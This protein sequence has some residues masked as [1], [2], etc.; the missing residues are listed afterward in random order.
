MDITIGI[1]L[2]VLFSGCVWTKENKHEYCL[3][4]STWGFTVPSGDIILEYGQS[5]N[6]TCNLYEEIAKDYINASSGLYFIYKEKRIPSDEVEIINSTSVRLYID[7]PPTSGYETYY[8]NFHETKPTKNETEK[9]VCMN[10][11]A[12]AVAPQNVTDFSCIG[13]NLDNL[14]CSWELPENYIKTDYILS[15][16]LNQ[17][18]SR[19]LQYYC[20]KLT[21][22][23]NRMS[24]FWNI[25]TKPQYRQVQPT[26]A[27]TLNMTNTFGSNLMKIVYD[28]FKHVIPNPPENLTVVSTSPHSIHLTW[29]IPKM[30]VYF[31]PGVH[32][33]IL[34]QCEYYE[35]KWEFVYITDWEKNETLEYDLNNMKYAHAVCDVRISMRSAVAVDDETMWSYYA[36]KTV[37]TKSDIPDLPPPM[38]QGCFEIINNQ[39]HRDVYIYW[40]QIGEEQKNGQNFK[41]EVV[42]ESHPNMKPQEQTKAYAKFTNLSATQYV[43]SVWSTNEKGKSENKSTVIIPESRLMEPQNFLKWDHP[44]TSLD[45]NDLY[46]LS[47]DAPRSSGKEITNYT[48]FWCNND[49]DRPHQ[50]TGNLNW[51]VIPV[52]ISKFNLSLP[53]NIIY[54]FAISANSENS[55]SGMSWAECTLIPSKIMGKMRNVWISLVGSTFIELGWKLE[56]TD[57]IRNVEGYRIY[58]CP[59][60]STLEK[61]CTISKEENVTIYGNKSLQSG[62]V[63]NLKPYTMYRLTVSVKVAPET[64]SQSSDIMINTT[65]E[66]APST[67]PK[68]INISN[69]TNSSLTIEWDPPTECNGVLKYYLINYRNETGTVSPDVNKNSK[70]FNLT[71]LRSYAKYFI[72]MQACTVQCSQPSE[73]QLVVTQ[74]WLPGDI[75]RPIVIFQNETVTTIQWEKPDDPR[76]EINYYQLRF[77][78]N[79][80]DVD[81][82]PVVNVTNAQN[83]SIK[84]CGES[85][86][87]NT[88]FVSVRA[89]N[90]IYGE[91][92]AGP[93]SEPIQFNCGHYSSLLYIILSVIMIS[94]VA[95]LFFGFRKIYAWCKVMRDVEVKLPPGLAP[96]VEQRD[97]VPWGSEKNPDDIDRSSRAD[98]QLLLEKIS[99]I[100]TSGDSSGCSSG[101]E[102]IT[103]SLESTTH[104]SIDSG[105]DQPRNITEENRRNSLRQRNVSSKGYVLPDAIPTIN[106]G[107]KPTPTPAGNYCVLGVDPSSKTEADS[108]YQPISDVNSSISLPYISCDLPPNIPQPFSLSSDLIKTLNP[109]YVPYSATEPASKNTGYVVAGLTKDLL[110]GDICHC[111]VLNPSTT[112]IDDKPYMKLAEAPTNIKGIQNPWQQ[113]TETV[114]AKPGY[115]SVG[116]ASPPKTIKEIAKGYVPHRQFEAKSL[117]E[118]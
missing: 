106:W 27:F 74:M 2:L 23:D 6:I 96:V 94:A 17:G 111:E 38:T 85:G 69:I 116:D 16:T 43:I 98:E 15:Y 103:S 61:E 108:P 68:N 46:E 18:R 114:T 97:L 77:T 81:V 50:C 84:H 14:T 86:K 40:Q 32:H 79:L 45:E 107:S 89:V 12:V 57:G 48:I 21:T 7:K 26:F 75:S 51:T 59:I 70:S 115:V 104:T 71:N 117:K 64:Y 82:E 54:Q 72:S 49:R 28:H 31:K 41:Y 25:S 65:R 78:D 67:P 105:T 30:M 36:S 44:A 3:K 118:D 19:N 5:L 22:A 80:K 95:A 109:G 83:Y 100:R 66:A 60:K 73:E 101:H 8:C 62:R 58:Y 110:P 29:V 1:Y 4:L 63:E 76:G 35:K 113:P 42:V 55:S 87:Y 56:C 33:R 24:C 93:W 37:R 11:V 9:L 91:H 112:K 53:R 10:V 34:Y 88:F 99:E 39:F 52:G 20:P 13:R 47:W 102:S 92:K 90:I